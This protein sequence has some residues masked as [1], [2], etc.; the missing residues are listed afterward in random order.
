MLWCEAKRNGDA[1]TCTML[2]RNAFTV[3]MLVLIHHTH[4]GYA[5]S[6][7]SPVCSHKGVG[8]GVP[9]QSG[10]GGYAIRVQGGG[11]ALLEA[12]RMGTPTTV[13]VKGSIPYKGILIQASDSSDEPVGSFA[14]DQLGEGLEVHPSCDYAVTHTIDHAKEPRAEDE[15]QFITPSPLVDGDIIKFK[16]TLVKDFITWYALEKTFIIGQLDSDDAPADE[17]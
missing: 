13:V 7:G 9:V 4:H 12:A 1:P 2:A 17:G 16:V 11:A 8:H 14:R 15:F 3:G 5:R 6:I 10:D